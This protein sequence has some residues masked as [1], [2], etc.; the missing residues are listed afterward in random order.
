[1][2]A[3]KGSWVHQQ[4][5]GASTDFQGKA[6]K[7]G[8]KKQKQK[9]IG[10]GNIF[11]FFLGGPPLFWGIPGGSQGSLVGCQNLVFYN[12]FKEVSSQNLV[13][14]NG[15]GEVTF[16]SLMLYSVFKEVSLQ[17]LVFYNVG[18]PRNP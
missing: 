4:P 11:S 10:F 2:L 9:N 16:E 17:N 6:K 14:Y 13:F 18:I 3:P 12:V 5:S 8:G 1:M 7:S 15:F